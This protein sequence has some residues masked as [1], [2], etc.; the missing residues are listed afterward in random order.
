M[1]SSILSRAF[2]A[3]SSRLPKMLSKFAMPAA[4]MPQRTM[5]TATSV[6]LEQRTMK[7]PGL[8]D[9]ITEGTI[10]EWTASVGQAVKEGDVVAMVET[11]KVTVDIKAEIDGVITEHFSAVD[12]TVEVGADLYVI[13]TEAEASVAASESPSSP[14]PASSEA[15]TSA[16]PKQAP[17][18]EVKQAAATSSTSSHRSPS[19]KFLGKDGW[20]RRRSA[21][22]PPAVVYIP[23][24]YGR[25]KISEDEMEALIMGGASMAPNVK[26]PS[27]G[28]IFA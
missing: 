2:T 28:A 1:A 5:V 17:A 3:Q 10:V 12:D 27:S 22:Q 16:P 18:P 24:M 4:V 11:D 13:D 8:G 14:P 25:P 6:L 20:A 9:S 19:I 23:P 15:T 7:L 21:V 26:V